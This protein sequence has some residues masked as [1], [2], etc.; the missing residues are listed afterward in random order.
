MKLPQHELS[1]VLIAD[2]ASLLGPH[3]NQK[4]TWSEFCKCYS[5]MLFASTHQKQN[6]AARAYGLCATMQHH[7][8]G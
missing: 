3:C 7:K 6:A 1:S 4:N 2:P 5:K 8:Q